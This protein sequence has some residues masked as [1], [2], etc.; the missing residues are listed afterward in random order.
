M[1]NSAVV[2]KEAC[3]R[4]ERS[5][6]P[7]WPSDSVTNSRAELL[8]HTRDRARVGLA[9]DDDYPFTT[10][11]LLFDEPDPV[12]HR[13]V[14]AR[15]S[16]TGMQ[17]EQRKRELGAGG[18]N[19]SCAQLVDLRRPIGDRYAELT[20]RRGKLLSGVH[21]RSD[22]MRANDKPE[23]AA[24]ADICFEGSIGIVQIRKD[25]IVPAEILAPT[26]RQFCIGDEETG[27]IR[28]VQCPL[29]ISG[30]VGETSVGDDVD[31]VE[32]AAQCPHN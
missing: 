1:R 23:Y 17:R 9:A 7:Q 28:I 32:F 3:A 11:E 29:G 18:C 30:E 25:E 20:Q 27:K 4:H 2:P 12:F 10:G 16:A 13:P 5:D 22:A 24:G 6:A 14:L 26:S 21:T 8:A 31:L 15:A 19:F